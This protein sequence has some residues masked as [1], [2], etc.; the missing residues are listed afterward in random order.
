M[1]A[2]GH[3]G[4]AALLVGPSALRPGQSPL[5]FVDQVKQNAKKTTKQRP[6]DEVTIFVVVRCSFLAVL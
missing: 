3:Y 2:A 6:D 5:L 4:T 1:A